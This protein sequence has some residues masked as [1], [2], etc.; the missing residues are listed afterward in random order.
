MEKYRVL[1]LGLIAALLMSVVLIGG[2][3]T[4]EGQEPAAEGDWTWI[5]FLVLIFAVFYFLM[6]MKKNY[7]S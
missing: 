2:C 6:I 5:I 7:K 1:I 3:I 4:P